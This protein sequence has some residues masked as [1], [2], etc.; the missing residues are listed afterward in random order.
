MS[1]FCGAQWS[2]LP[3]DAD[4]QLFD[5]DG[6]ATKGL[7]AGYEVIEAHCATY[8]LYPTRKE[9][10]QRYGSWDAAV[11]FGLDEALLPQYIEGIAPKFHEALVRAP[12]QPGFRATISLLWERRRRI[13]L[14]SAGLEAT[15]RAALRYHGLEQFMES[16]VTAEGA[17]HQ[18]PHPEPL[19]I[20]MS[21][22]GAEPSRTVMYGDSYT[23]DIAAA[24][25]AG[26]NAVLFYPPEYH[27]IYNYS[28]E[29]LSSVPVIESWREVYN[30]LQ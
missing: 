27:D 25:A 29:V 1:R 12:L 5:W 17:E 11:H 3:I 14:V 15:I 4:V 19:D 28:P 2:E 20:A 13:A 24:R 26:T 23:K 10:V 21:R 16:I 9:V 18:K 6:T 22:F 7:E 8:G 30:R